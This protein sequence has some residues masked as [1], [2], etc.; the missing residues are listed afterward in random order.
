MQELMKAKDSAEERHERLAEVVS[1]VAGTDKDMTKEL[2]EDIL[3]VAD[4]GLP[5]GPLLTG[6]VEVTT[7]MTVATR[8]YWARVLA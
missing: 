6:I 3:K 4:G 5:V 2:K 7:G 1:R 8:R